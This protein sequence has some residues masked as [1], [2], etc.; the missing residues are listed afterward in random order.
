M[1]AARERLLTPQF[2]TVTCAGVVPALAT[3]AAKSNTSYTGLYT[4]VG[5]KSQ[6]R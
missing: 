3:T 6:P 4:T 1:P 5:Q 2:L